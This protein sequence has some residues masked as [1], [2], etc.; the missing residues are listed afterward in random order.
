MRFAYEGSSVEALGWAGTAMQQLSLLEARMAATGQT[1]GA[2][3]CALSND[4]YC[5]GYVLP[6]GMRAIYVVAP[7]KLEDETAT[8]ATKVEIPDFVSG[9]IIDGWIPPAEV[10]AEG[11]IQ[12]R[13]LETF[14]PTLQT[15]V[16][17]KDL[18]GLQA[19]K[20]ARL[21]VDLWPAY[22]DELKAQRGQRSGSQYTRFKPSMFSGRMRE[23]VQLIGGFGK[24]P[25]ESIYKGVEPKLDE[26]KSGQPRLASSWEARAKQLGR[27]IAY[28]YR[29]SRTHGIFMSGTVPWLVEIGINRGVIAMRLPINPLTKSSKF[30]EKLVKV[31]DLD[32][33]KAYDDWGG[34]PTGEPFPIGGPALESAIR[35]GKVIR[36]AEQSAMSAYYGE[37]MP[38]SQAMGWAFNEAGDEAHNT[39][40]KYGTDGVQRGAHHAIRINITDAGLFTKQ[41]GAEAMKIAFLPVKA[42]KSDVFEEVMWKVDRL[43]KDQFAQVTKDMDQLGLTKAFENLDALVLA[44]TGSG[45]ASLT[46]VSEGK[47]YWPTP[48]GQ[49]QMKFPDY[50]LGFIISHDLRPEVLV[51]S[52]DQSCDTTVHVF[53]DG[54]QLK[55]VKYFLQPSNWRTGW[56]WEGDDEFDIAN[57]PVGEFYRA[58]VLGPIGVPPGYYSN[59]IDPR[60][61]LPVSK[62][63]WF[64]HRKRVGPTGPWNFSHAIPYPPT[65]FC[66]PLPDVGQTA[67]ATVLYSTCWFTTDYD[68]HYSTSRQIVT[69]MAVPIGE[70]E[71]YYFATLKTKTGGSIQYARGFTGINSPWITWRSENDGDTILDDESYFPGHAGYEI[72]NYQKDFADDGPL[73]H[74]GEDIYNFRTTNN[75]DP[76]HQYNWPPG[77][78]SRV[79]YVPATGTLETWLVCHSPFSPIRVEYETR[80]GD[81]NVGYWSPLWFQ[82]SPNEYGDFQYIGVN[83]NCYGQGTCL[84]YQERINSSTQKIVGAPNLPAM[85][86]VNNVIPSVNFVGVVDG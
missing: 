10:N 20:S 61:E 9:T 72:Y 85:Q 4:A 32:G 34:W 57:T 69:G 38:Y 56:T 19:T 27:Q 31:G 7:P 21:A 11:V 76:Y 73:G 65:Q 1:Q 63:E 22:A 58:Y 6:T 40:Y 45:T 66:E 81:E 64:Y 54:M 3:Q 24:T 42:T 52:N 48:L 41:R 12:P 68:F 78:S 50:A 74:V 8:V 30:R 75:D 23:V 46:K 84:V 37:W 47:L 49:P 35:S 83:T 33:Q 44:P 67:T 25:K 55:W 82:P 16:V 51:N 70:R 86:A 29:F 28:D 13:I 18:T 43:S 2:F 71:A 26:E 14:Y 60:E 15:A 80:T 17:H 5:Y 36:L 59:D 62:F 77:Y 79:V 39:A 53:F